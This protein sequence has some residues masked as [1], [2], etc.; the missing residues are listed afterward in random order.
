MRKT[1]NRPDYIVGL[2][3]GQAQDFSALA[4][5]ER[6]WL[7]G[8]GK[9]RQS[10]YAVRHL[11][12]W[13]L[14][15]PYSAIV[16]EVGNLVASPP[17]NHAL[18]AVDQ[19]GVGSAVVDMLRRPRLKTVLRP[20][21]ITAGHAVSMDEV[22]VYHVARIELVS[23]M[24]VL[25]GQQRLKVASLPERELLGQEL[26]AFRVQVTTV[27]NDTF[28]SWRERDH[29]DLV[30][31]VALAAWLGERW[32]MPFVAPEPVQRPVRRCA[33]PFG[34]KSAAAWQGLFGPGR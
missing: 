29:H 27:S 30:L 6:R 11:Q 13:P 4:V 28:E 3:L 31:A 8:M 2:D 25:L 9:R 16:A 15:T 24:Q 12:R 17:L 33:D 32:G 23:V 10:L 26:L 21:L 34:G 18:M 5:L 14:G 19:T 20:V 7:E 1:P 22:G